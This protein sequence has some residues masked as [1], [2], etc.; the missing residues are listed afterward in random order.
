MRAS[1]LSG[2]LAPA[3]PGG[4]PADAVQ[5]AVQALP[6][7]LR[8]VL[9]LIDVEG[10]SYRQ[11]A[12][13]MDTRIGVVA[14]RLRRARSWLRMCL[15]PVIFAH[16]RAPVTTGPP[17]PLGNLGRAEDSH[18]AHGI[19]GHHAVG[20]CRPSPRLPGRSACCR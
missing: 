3:A 13:V 18:P 20:A 16:A 5:K 7:D 4:V 10:L 14:A 11:A 12:Q 9:Y 17:A 1:A 8:I 15:A 19:R 2:A 6:A